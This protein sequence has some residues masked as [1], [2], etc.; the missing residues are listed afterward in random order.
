MNNY[1]DPMYNADT[2]FL[3]RVTEMASL[4]VETIKT[5]K[6]KKM[7]RKWER[8]IIYFKGR[9]FRGKKLSR[10]SRILG[11]FAKVISAKNS[12]EADS[13]KF[14][15]A[16]KIWTTVDSRN[17]Q[18]FGALKLEGIIKGINIDSVLSS[19][20]TDKHYISLN[21]K[22]NTRQNRFCIRYKT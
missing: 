20:Y 22:K 6:W 11:K 14:F 4:E 5:E 3:Q 19:L 17:F 1:P 2:A 21:N 7:R 10:F 12:A 9:N 13:R 15:L 16:K 18:A 8:T